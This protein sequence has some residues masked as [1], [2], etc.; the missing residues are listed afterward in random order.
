M[1]AAKQVLGSAKMVGLQQSATVLERDVL[2]ELG[3]PTLTRQ[4]KRR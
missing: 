3:D 4:S 2:E 1:R